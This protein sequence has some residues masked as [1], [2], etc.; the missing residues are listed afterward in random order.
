[1]R[2][3]SMVLSCLLVPALIASACYGGSISSLQ[4]EIAGLFNKV[5][6]SVP[7]VVY[8]FRDKEFVSTGIVMD[9][10][11]HILTTKDFSGTPRSIEVQF[12][13]DRRDAKLVGYDRE[14]KL[15]VLKVDNGGFTPAKMGN[16]DEVVPT[17]WVMIVGNS[18]GV[19]PSVSVG[20]ISGRRED[21]DM[22]QISA[23][24][25]PGNS[26]A[27]VFNSEGE[28]IGIVSA[29]LSRPLYITMGGGRQKLSAQFKYLSR[30]GLPLGGSGLLIPMNRARKMM[31]RIIEHGTTRYG[32]LG[33]RLQTLDDLL[34]SALDVEHGAL[35]SDVIE[36]GPAEKAGIKEGDVILSYG[37]K[38]V[39]DVPHMVEI[40]RGTQPGEKV[41]LVVSRKG[42]RKGLKV[43]IG[44]RPEEDVFQRRWHI[45]MPEVEEFYKSAE[46]KR[47]EAV[48]EKLREEIKKLK[49]E[50]KRMRKEGG[51]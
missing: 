36:N 42:K 19:S 35:V 15:A 2:L 4:A 26:G 28:L 1:M 9:G 46:K 44:E 18:L 49:G 27:G 41:K 11:G 12:L 17:T 29:T 25:T 31:K 22:L 3:T 48:V 5:K 47:L 14:S 34:K 10:E 51:L 16:S 7:T 20:L 33:V 21:D 45:Q 39:K 50:L 23:S 8:T 30:V 40:V 24:I 38:H 13:K 37:G 43:R 32:W 6:P